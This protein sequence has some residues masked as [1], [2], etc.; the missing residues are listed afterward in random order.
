MR[1]IIKCIII[2]Y[3]VSHTVERGSESQHSAWY[4]ITDCAVWLHI[5]THTVV[6][7]E[8]KKYT[9]ISYNDYRTSLTIFYNVVTAQYLNKKLW[10]RFFDDL[11]YGNLSALK[12]LWSFGKKPAIKTSGQ[13]QLQRGFLRRATM[14]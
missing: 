8:W 9:I 1:K 13:N 4:T 12:S 10:P 14:H 2:K 5:G 3:R 6:T 11:S 7:S